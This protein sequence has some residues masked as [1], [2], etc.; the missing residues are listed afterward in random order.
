MA[1]P[2]KGEHGQPAETT[3]TAGDKDGRHPVEYTILRAQFAAR[4]CTYR[5]PH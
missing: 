2:G 3:V 4:I 1:L 5:T